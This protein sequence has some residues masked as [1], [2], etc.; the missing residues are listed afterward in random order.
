[1]LTS[2]RLFTKGLKP[3]CGPALQKFR[4]FSSTPEGEDD[5]LLFHPVYDEAGLDVKV[6]H[7]K[8]KKPTD[9]IALGILRAVRITFDKLTGYGPNMTEDKF[10]NRCIFLETVAG[11]PGISGALIRHLRSLRS[12]TRDN[13]RIHTLLEE[14]ENERMHLLTMLELKQPSKMFKAATYFSQIGFF[15]GYTTAFAFFPKT[16]HRFIGYLEEEAVLTYVSKQT[17]YH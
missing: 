1:M 2:T 5:Y 14:A 15:A 3:A 13:G 8:P 16:C 6:T 12:C 9:Y 17:L 7:R 11:V 4:L 10:I